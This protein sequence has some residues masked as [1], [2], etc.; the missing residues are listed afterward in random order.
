MSQGKT[1]INVFK[2][3]DIVYLTC[4]SLDCSCV[5]K[6]ISIATD[7]TGAYII[8]NLRYYRGPGCGFARGC[9]T[10]GIREECIRDGWKISLLCHEFLKLFIDKGIDNEKEN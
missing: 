10:V 5:A 1:V 7:C 4:S 6:I 9:S 2:S 3:G 8:E